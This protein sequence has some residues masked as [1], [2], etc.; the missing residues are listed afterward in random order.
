[1]PTKIW[2]MTGGTPNFWMKPPHISTDFKIFS[3]IFQASGIDGAGFCRH[4][5][6]FPLTTVRPKLETPNTE[7]PV[8]RGS[9]GGYSLPPQVG[10]EQK[11][12]RVELGFQTS[13]DFKAW[14]G[15]FTSNTFQCISIHFNIYILIDFTNFCFCASA[16]PGSFD[17]KKDVG[18]EMKR[19]RIPNIPKYLVGG[20]EHFL[21][22][23]ILEIIIPTD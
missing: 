19:K 16:S 13:W 1:M 7:R 18:R 22:S 9:S 14:T 12:Q 20:L 17:P 5:H 15:I 11:S 23:H 6:D 8:F 2:M 21:F 10:A 4:P 3:N